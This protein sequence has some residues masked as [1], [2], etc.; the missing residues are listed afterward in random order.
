MAVAT[1][2]VR[3]EQRSLVIALRRCVRTVSGAMWSA[4]AIVSFELPS[5]RSCSTSIS[6][7]RE[8]RLDDPSAFEHE[9]GER[10]V[11]VRLAGRDDAYGTHELHERRVLLDHTVR[12]RLERV[13]NER[14]VADARVD[15]ELRAG[16]P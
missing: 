3:V 10:S 15:E 11:D 16:H 5:A 8:T 14:L 4:D 1:A 13:R 12:A 2:C 6:R 9:V 7:L